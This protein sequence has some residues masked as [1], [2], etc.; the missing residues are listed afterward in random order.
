VPVKMC[1]L[2]TLGFDEKLGL[3][4]F[5]DHVEGLG[6]RLGGDMVWE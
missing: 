3:V 1:Q 2:S 5:P 6:M 4:S